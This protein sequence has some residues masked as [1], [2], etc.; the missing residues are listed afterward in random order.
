MGKLSSSGMN[1]DKE[2]FLTERTE[3][4]V[5]YA[6]S[7]ERDGFYNSPPLKRIIR[8]R[9]R[10]IDTAEMGH[11]QSWKKIEDKKSVIDSSVSQV[12]SARMIL[13]RILDKEI[14]LVPYDSVLGCLE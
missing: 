6:S 14:V 13:Q 2:E 1:H 11:T 12:A 7:N 4:S 3:F 9:I 5:P 8:P 10:N